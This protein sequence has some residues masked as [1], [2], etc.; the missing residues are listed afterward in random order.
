MGICIVV[1][2]LQAKN[3]GPDDFDVG[4]AVCLFQ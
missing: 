3:V 1:S 2:D 4:C